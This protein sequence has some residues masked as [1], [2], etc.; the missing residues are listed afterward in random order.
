MKRTNYTARDPPTP[1]KWIRS[2][3]LS[4]KNSKNL[5][6]AYSSTPS[7]VLLQTIAGTDS[8]S[9]RYLNKWKKERRKKERKKTVMH[10]INQLFRFYRL[11]SV[12]A[13]FKGSCNRKG[14]ERSATGGKGER[15]EGK[16]GVPIFA[17]L[18]RFVQF[19]VGDRYGNLRAQEFH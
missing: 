3:R 13:S 10:K 14:Y 5:S 15:G 4:P 7:A 11:N 2:E 12:E 17:R 9:A 8:D 16:R 19:S 1:S 6:L 18:H